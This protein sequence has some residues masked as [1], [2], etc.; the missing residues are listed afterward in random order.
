MLREQRNTAADRRAQLSR[1]I[2]QLRDQVRSEQQGTV[3]WRAK[4]RPT[5]DSSPPARP[6][7]LH[8]P[9]APAHPTHPRAP[10]HSTLPDPSPSAQ[11][12]CPPP[13]TLATRIINRQRSSFSRSRSRSSSTSTSA[14]STFTRIAWASSSSRHPVRP[15]APP[16]DHAV[17]P[18]KT[19]APN[20][21][22]WTF[23]RRQPERHFPARPGLAAQPDLRLCRACQQRQPVRRS[24]P[25]GPWPLALRPRPC[26]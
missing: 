2:E 20:V 11:P 5:P 18:E 26:F 8:P 1:E 10:A 17:A 13:L 9:R 16:I 25:I 14:P 15:V 3:A 4:R 23:H 12:T 21:A 19:H 7:P 6:C 24:V 22:A